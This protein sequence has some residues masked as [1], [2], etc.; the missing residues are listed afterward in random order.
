MAA[1]D[2]SRI[3]LLESNVDRHDRDITKIWE[4]VTDLKI[5]ASSLPTIQS[6]IS[7]IEKNY[8]KLN[9][10][11]QTDRIFSR[12]QAAKWAGLILLLNGVITGI[13]IYVLTRGFR[14]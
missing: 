5:C 4:D 3:C 7:K 8:G 13:V 12:E 11:L 10:D 2:L 6:S 9:E 14:V 1:N